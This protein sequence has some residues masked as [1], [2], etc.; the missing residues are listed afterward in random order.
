MNRSTRP[1]VAL[2][3]TAALSLGGAVVTTAHA[4][5]ATTLRGTFALQPGS[6]AGGGTTGSYFRM[7]LHSGG[8]SGP[9][10]GNSSSACD[11]Q[12]YTLLEPGKDG[13]LVTGAYQPQ[14]SP[15]FD[16]D[17]NGR[18]NRV[19]KPTRFYGVDFTASTNPADPQTG[20]KVP[21]PVVTAQ[22]TTLS[23][24]L[25][26]FSVAWNNQQFNQGSPKPDGSLPGNTRR[27][28]GT[29]DA[30][31]GAFTLQWTSQIQGGPFDGFTGLWHLTGR[32][33]PA[34][35]PVAVPT[36]ARPSTGTT[37]PPGT[38]VGTTPPKAVTS[39]TAGPGTSGAPTSSGA[40]TA[41]ATAGS[42]TPG[43]TDT[44]Q[45]DPTTSADV[46]VPQSASSQDG[47]SVQ[48]PWALVAAVLA[49]GAG[50]LVLRLRA[51]R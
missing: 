38:T 46:A 45:P 43:E 50:G 51:Q 16:S 13:G 4:A 8:P 42:P 30:R 17:G 39:P 12:S 20:K 34:G 35:E 48:W 7:I 23:A 6:C 18:A 33:T 10:L 14:P 5:A 9:F 47:G 44:S 26:S 2:L 25:R 1:L 32:F 15:A 21:T 22:G 49:A 19:I 11:D 31:T 41:T 3:A 40:P 24:D 37:T 29:Y 27:A 36:T 28:T